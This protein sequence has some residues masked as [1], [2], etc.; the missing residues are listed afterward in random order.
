MP[1]FS[2][3]PQRL[4]DYW[5]SL[6][7]SAGAT[8]P[9]RANFSVKG[10][11]S[12]MQEVF[13]IEWG[14]EGTLRILQIGTKLDQ[15]L[16]HDLTHRDILEMVP[17]AHLSGELAFYRNLCGTPCAGMTTHSF[18]STNG[19]PLLYKAVLLPLLDTAGDVRFFVGAGSIL[20]A[21]DAVAGFGPEYMDFWQLPKREYL[22]IGAGLPPMNEYSYC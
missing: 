15:G 2:K 14:N 5:T 4:I 20:H 8:C 3:T 16:G 9:T 12:F 17:K 21:E 22:D 19:R 18:Q 7:T 6:P 13:T 1:Q 11:T 10:I